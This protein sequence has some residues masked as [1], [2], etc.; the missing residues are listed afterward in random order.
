M[1]KY[2]L[3]KR[4]EEVLQGARDRFLRFGEGQSEKPDDLDLRRQAQI[5]RQ[6]EI[7]NR[8]LE[9]ATYEDLLRELTETLVD[10]T[11]VCEEQRCTIEGIRGDS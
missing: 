10:L 4:A 2:E 3:A 7:I 8:L 11:F 9:G 6:V 5:A 1:A